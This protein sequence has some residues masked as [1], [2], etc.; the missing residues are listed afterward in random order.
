MIKV[1]YEGDSKMPSALLA[2]VPKGKRDDFKKMYMPDLVTEGIK[3]VLLNDLMKEI[4]PNDDMSAGW[5]SREAARHGS[6]RALK[7][8]LDLLP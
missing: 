6:I 4:M 7:K 1:I 5:E 3:Q 8:A 2:V